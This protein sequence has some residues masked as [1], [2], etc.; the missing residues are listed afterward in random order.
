[1]KRTYS[2][3][4]IAAIL[5]SLVVVGTMVFASGVRLKGDVDMNGNVTSSDARSILRAAVALEEFTEEQKLIADMDNNTIVDSSDARL[6]L[7]VAVRLDAL[8]TMEDTTV[9]TEPTTEPPVEPSTDPA[10]EPS[11]EPSTAPVL[12]LTEDTDCVISA[13]LE[14]LDDSGKIRSRQVVAAHRVVTGED[15]VATDEFYYRGSDF[16]DGKDIGLILRETPAAD[17]TKDQALTLIAYESKE[18]FGFPS[19]LLKDTNL[20]VEGGVSI[21]VYFCDSIDGIEGETVTV[22]DKEYFVVTEDENAI[23]GYNKLYL[24]PYGDGQYAVEIREAYDAAGMLSKRITLDMDSYQP[25]ADSAFSL[26]GLTGK[27]YVDNSIASLAD[28]IEKL[29]AIGITF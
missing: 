12:E 20:A 21:P 7:R 2:A 29:N 28:L 24:A 22:G 11:T 23:G 17:G 16:F 3:V 4:A 8:V 27:E 26:D 18:Y 19:A 25:D 1:M 15:G 13:T 10:T 14:D 5:L 9:P 6:A